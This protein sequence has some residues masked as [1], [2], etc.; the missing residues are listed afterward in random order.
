VKSST[1]YGVI[2]KITNLINGKIYIGQTKQNP[3]KRWCSHKNNSKNKKY[4]NISLI[5]KAIYK[6][7][8]ENFTFEIIDSARCAESLNR[9]EGYYITTLCSLTPKGYNIESFSNE[10]RITSEETKNK[11]IKK[12]TNRKTNIAS[13]KFYGVYFKKSI[14]K[15]QAVIHFKNKK[16]HIGYFSLE[17]DAAK[18]RDIEILKNKY[19]DILE[20]NYPELKEEYLGGNIFVNKHNQKDETKNKSKTK[21]KGIYF[22]KTRNKWS[23]SISYNGKAKHLGRFN[24]E[25]EAATKYNEAVIEYYGN[26]AVFNIIE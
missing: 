23:A 1:F 2:Y 22:D 24:T 6:Y 17:E 4:K 12:I 16:T 21:Y 7:G 19:N 9:L 25:I 26:D 8:E 13:S 14:N 11:I 15:W 3:N 10:K 5:S 20:L 18:A